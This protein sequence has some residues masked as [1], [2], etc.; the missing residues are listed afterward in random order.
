MIYN[1]L[2]NLTCFILAAEQF[3]K[4][5]KAQE[6]LLDAE[7][8]RKYDQWIGSGLQ[9]SFE[10]WLGLEKRLHSVRSL[11]V[12]CDDDLSFAIQS[13]HWGGERKSKPALSDN[14]RRDDE[15]HATNSDDSR[16]D[17]NLEDFRKGMYKKIQQCVI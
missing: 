2:C 17:G 13:M 8:R 10:D 15:Q 16:P 6:V 11:L 5:N 1:I 4:L 3:V 7:M 12:Y 14:T 9:I